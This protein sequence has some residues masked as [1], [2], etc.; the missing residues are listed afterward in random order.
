MGWQEWRASEVMTA[1]PQAR[2]NQLGYL[3]GRAK[4]ATLISDAEKPVHFTVR[5]RG[6]GIVPTGLSRPCSIRP[7]PTSGLNVHVLDFTALN[8]QGAGFR[9]E[10]DDQGS[11]PFKITNRLYEQLAADALRFFYTWCQVVPSTRM[12]SP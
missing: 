6:G 10:A 9:I 11:H 3:I 1:R 2:V 8:M 7:E 5:D 12:P 4:Q